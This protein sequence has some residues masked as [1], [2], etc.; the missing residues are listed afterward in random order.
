MLLFIKDNFQADESGWLTRKNGKD[1]DESRGT[2][3][4]RVGL[5]VNVENWI[6]LI[7]RL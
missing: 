1:K 6:F 3:F 2:Q 5:Q 7:A 4:M